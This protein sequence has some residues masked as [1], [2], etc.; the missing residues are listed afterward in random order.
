M[1]SRTPHSVLLGLDGNRAFV[2]VSTLWTLPAP[3]SLLLWTVAVHVFRSPLFSLIMAP[4]CKNSAAGN[5]DVPERS[6]TALPLSEK[7]SMYRKKHSMYRVWS[8]PWFPA[9]PGG[10][11]KY[12]RWIRETYCTM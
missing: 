1:K 6:R 5:L 3:Q 7:A 2:S 4:K 8:Y 9:F 11:G 10:R 12:P